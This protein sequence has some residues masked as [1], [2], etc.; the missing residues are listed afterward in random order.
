MTAGEAANCSPIANHQLPPRA[1]R[2]RS[3]LTPEDIMDA[4][5]ARLLIERAAD[6]ATRLGY[7][8]CGPEFF[9]ITAA[10]SASPKCVEVL[11][12]Y[13][14]GADSLRATVREVLGPMGETH[15]PTAVPATTMRARRAIE[16]AT[17]I[18]AS[19]GRAEL[20]ADDLLVGLLAEDVARRGVIH[21]VLERRGAELAVLRAELEATARG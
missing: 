7:E 20:S 12:R 19:H 5:S 2:L 21:A 18:A 15:D 11:A 1:A 3:R 16:H 10:E 17:G 6:E 8:Y 13:G 9:L 14:L 4:P